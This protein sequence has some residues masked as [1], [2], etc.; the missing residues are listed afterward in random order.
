MESFGYFS[1]GNRKQFDDFKA[2]Q[3]PDYTPHY[4][5]PRHHHRKGWEED[6]LTEVDELSIDKVS[7]PPPIVPPRMRR[8]QRTYQVKL[9]SETEDLV[10][11]KHGYHGGSSYSGHSNI[12]SYFT[13]PSMGYSYFSM[14]VS[15]CTHWAILN[16]GNYIIQI[17]AV[18]SWLH[19][20]YGT[21]G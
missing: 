4:I 6:S 16:C 14:D 19:W 1:S 18:T 3:R 7:T 5:R 17:F 13:L 21:F 8:Q 12:P 10:P 15:I 2:L 9:S 20:F 11:S